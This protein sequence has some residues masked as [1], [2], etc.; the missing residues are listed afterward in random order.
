MCYQR[1]EYKGA[2]MSAK[3][4]VT[5]QA[6]GCVSRCRIGMKFT[7]TPQ[8]IEVDNH[9]LEILQNDSFL[10][11]TVLDDGGVNHGS[12]QPNTNP[13]PPNEPPPPQNNGDDGTG[14]DGQSSS[15]T[16]PNGENMGNTTLPPSQESGSASA[17]NEN[18]GKQSHN[19]SN[20]DTSA[21]IVLKMQELGFTG[22]EDK[23][24]TC[25]ELK[26]LGLV[27]SAKERDQAWAIL[28]DNE[29]E[30]EQGDK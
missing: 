2:V 8:E 9:Q 12:V 1:N 19:K 29:T 3:T 11:V 25:D 4:L 18:D 14:K 10:K 6:I 5:V 28:Q 16:A 24:P 23:K 7:Q 30:T 27:V 22:A 15:N 17:I 13:L 26:A 20:D 21:T